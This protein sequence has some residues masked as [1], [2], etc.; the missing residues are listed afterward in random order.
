MYRN[1][2]QNTPVKSPGA[3]SLRDVMLAYHDFQRASGQQANK[4]NL[5]TLSLWQS[6]RL[7]ATH[8]D[9]YESPDY[10]TGL[11]F[12]LSDLYAPQDFSRRD[13]ELERVFPKLVKLL[14]DSILSTVS[15]LIELNLLT[16]KL[17][18]HLSITHFEVLGFNTITELTYC[19]AYRQCNNFDDRK[20]QIGLINEVGHKLNRYARSTMISYS[21]KLTSHPAEMAGLGSLHGFIRRGFSAFH[22][23]RDIQGLMQELV[24]RESRILNNIANH[25]PSPFSLTEHS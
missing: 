9:L 17:D 11:K 21:L 14:P 23:M 5:D 6:Q 24:H 25:H 1:R 16:Q 20:H 2:I 19:E 8:R 18:H 7:K 3:Q 13:Q 12:L 22:T 4:E 15:R 10:A